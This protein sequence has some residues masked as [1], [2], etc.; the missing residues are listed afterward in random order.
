MKIGTVVKNEYQGI[1]RYGKINAAFK[2]DDD[3]TWY[4][5]D[6]VDDEQYQEAILY[7]N[8]LSGKDHNKPFY[9]ADELSQIDINKTIKTLLKLQNN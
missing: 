8:S 9:S 1:V 7:R 4:E 3:W 2:G 6:W 5:I